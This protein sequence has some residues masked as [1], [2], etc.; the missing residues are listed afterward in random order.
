MS[1]T[2]ILQVLASAVTVAKL[3][4]RTIRLLKNA[5]NAGSHAQQIRQ[6]IKQLHQIVETVQELVDHRKDMRRGEDV[7]SFEKM[8]WKHLETSLKACR[9]LLEKLEH[10][11]EVKNHPDPGRIRR[12]FVEI[13]LDWDRDEIERF[14]R[15]LNAHVQA[16]HVW[17]TSL[18]V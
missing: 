15:I 10:A 9:R 12:A 7:P 11:V 18:Q 16:I 5:A 17:I 8:I 14:G 13:R 3:A 1:G 2:E 4:R 6:T